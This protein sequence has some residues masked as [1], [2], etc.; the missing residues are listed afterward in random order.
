MAEQFGRRLAACTLVGISLILATGRCLAQSAPAG[1]TPAPSTA[2]P[3]IGQLLQ[4]MQQLES[5]V[6][7]VQQLRTQVNQLQTEL[8]TLRQAPR[9]TLPPLPNPALGNDPAEWGSPRG[10]VGANRAGGGGGAGPNSGGGGGTP[11]SAGAGASGKEAGASGAG[12][13]GGGPVSGPSGPSK[14]GGQEDDD[15][16][17]HLNY[18]DNFG[19]G[20]FQLSDKDGEFTL[21]LQNQITVD[22]TF[23][24]RQNMPTS[25]KGFNIP[26]QRLYLYGNITKEWEYQ[27]AAQGFLGGF[28]LLDAFVNVH[29]DD[30]FMF[31]LG[32]MLSPF[33]IEYYGFSPAWEPVITNSPLFQLAG[34]R[35]VGAMLWGKLFDN[36]LQYQAGVY[37][38]VSGAFFDLDKNKD[39]LGAFTVMPF[40]GDGNVVLDSLGVGSSVQTGWQNYMLNAGNSNNFVNG[41]G[42][43]TTNQNYITSTGVPFFTYNNDVRAWGER[44]KIAPHFFWLGRFSLLAEY[45]VE[46]RQLANTVTTGTSVQHGF[47]VN[48]SYFLTG[49]RYNGDGTGLYTTI[50]PISPFRPS[51]HQWG[52]GAWEIAAQFSELNV[53]TRDFQNGFSDPTRSTNRLD[54]LMVGMNWWPNK[55]VRVSFDWVYD[56]FNNQIPLAGGNPIDR[57]NIFWTRIAMFF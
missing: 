43:P 11:G 54:Q 33:L 4:R 49:E 51:Q 29:Y 17:I 28:N 3:S 35:Q 50:S 53:G 9:T 1:P 37:N 55:Y 10:N 56:K 45:V 39:F 36:K 22:G 21:K 23:Y 24:D 44:T 7:K 57:F 30:R 20:Y 13:G 6:Q 8:T 25:E 48:A 42:E 16:P 34:K 5:E 27:V 14:T 15:W 18:K 47:Y 19:G 26:F 38:G 52:P 41:A 12:G 31:K 2:D 40:K 32:R 46:S